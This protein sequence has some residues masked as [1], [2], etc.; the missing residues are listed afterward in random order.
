[1]QDPPS[2]S[3]SQRRQRKHHNN[4]NNKRQLNNNNKLRREKKHN[5]NQRHNNHKSY[6]DLCK[7]DKNKTMLLH[8]LMVMTNKLINTDKVAVEVATAEAAIEEATE[9]NL[10]EIPEETMVA[11]EVAVVAAVST[12]EVEEAALNTNLEMIEVMHITT[13]GMKTHIM[14]PHQT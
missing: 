13:I 4:N 9:D 1:M 12:E 14:K 7:T 11:I 2:Q 8:L 10:V 3:K 6:K 5:S